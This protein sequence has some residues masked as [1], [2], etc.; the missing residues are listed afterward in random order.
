[1]VLKKEAQNWLT[2]SMSSFSSP[3]YPESFSEFSF[4]VLLGWV[5]F[6][7]IYFGKYLKVFVLF[8][9]TFLLAGLS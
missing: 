4:S 3:P 6:S 8:V 7:Y 1:M 2:R 5:S 9:K